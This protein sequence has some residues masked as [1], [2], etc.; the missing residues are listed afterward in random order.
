MGPEIKLSHKVKKSDREDEEY[1][2]DEDG[3][4]D[5]PPAGYG[6]G[7]FIQ[8]DNGRMFVRKFEIV[9]LRW[10]QYASDQA[11]WCWRLRLFFSDCPNMLVFGEE[12][13]DVMRSFGLPEGP[14]G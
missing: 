6:E 9:G 5:P 11:E 12:A 2:D 7:D 3:D 13:A 1:G 4:Y 8:L 10:E 14:P